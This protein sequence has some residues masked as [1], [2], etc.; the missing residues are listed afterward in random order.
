MPIGE[1]NEARKGPA[2][3]VVNRKSLSFVAVIGGLVLA[4]FCGSSIF[5]TN[6]I[7][8]YTIRQTAIFGYP[9]VRTKPG[10]FP[11]LFGGIYRYKQAQAINFTDKADEKVE[12]VTVPPLSVRYKEGSTGTV[13]VNFRYRL[14]ANEKY[15]VA[16]HKEFRGDQAMM[17]SLIK[18]MVRQAVQITASLRTAE[19]SYAG[20]RAAYRE[21]VDDQLRNGLFKTVKRIDVVED[22]IT[23]EKRTTEVFIKVKDSKT[24]KVEREDNSLAKFGIEVQDVFVTH[25]DYD[26]T[27]KELIKKKREAIQAA[28]AAKAKAEQ[29]KQERITAEEEGKKNVMTAKYQKEVEKVKAVTDAQKELEVARLD[30][31]SAE[32]EKAAKIL[33][34]EGEAIAKAKIMQADG[35]LQPRLDAYI[36]TQTIWANAFKDFKGKIVPEVVMGADV[37]GT[38]GDNAFRQMMQLM[39]IKSAKDLSV[40][41]KAT[42]GSKK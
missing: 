15:L 20:G 1:I 41:V 38:G 11:Q 37:N 31:K 14:P 16:I 2:K 18:P 23:K 6:D 19:E 30:R 3:K 7:G 5:E 26:A 25:L 24:G 39:T 22:P 36:Q 21:D 17:D 33:R 29:A 32:Q 8:Y 27:V 34:G 40:D 10:M 28:V 13:F 42:R 9:Y 35:A 12:G 4:A